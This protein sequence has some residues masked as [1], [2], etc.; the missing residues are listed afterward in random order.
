MNNLSQEKATETNHQQAKQVLLC[1][2]EYGQTY[3][4]AIYQKK[5]FE[6]AGILARGS[7]QS[8][9][10]AEQ[11]GVSLYT[12]VDEIDEPIDIACVAINETV[13]TPIA[14][15]LLQKG[16]STLVEHPLSINSIQQLITTATNS[17]T[18][19]QIN[20]HFAE[21]PPIADFIRVCQILNAT[22]TPSVITIF[23]NS[24]TLFSTLDVLMRCFGLIHLQQ[25]STCSANHY[26][27]CTMLLSGDSI[28]NLS[29]TL[30]Y[31]QWRYE[32]D[33]SMDSPLGHQIS[34][35][36]P[37]GV[38]NLAG[39]F[40]PCLWFPLM[41]AGV[42]NQYPLCQ[43]TLP[44][45]Q[46]PPT[47]QTIIEWRKLANQQALDQLCMPVHECPVQHTPAY[48]TH[49]CNLWTTLFA[50]L[51]KTIIPAQPIGSFENYWDIHAMLNQ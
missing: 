1:G 49:L 26:Q 37:R 6:L 36:Y 33:N 47:L 3:L 51:G 29:C 30:V 41:A 24:R 15:Q 43:S 11:H 8:I 12:R 35:T 9:R 7:D 31:Q 4:P 13:G 39:S 34:I 50:Q 48:M 10:L 40:G 2:T 20:S 45:R 38:L 44:D 16:I 27:H 28:T 23:C 22:S 14:Q 18:R 21:L 5:G 25:L 32:Q 46:S 17:N 42:P 19:C